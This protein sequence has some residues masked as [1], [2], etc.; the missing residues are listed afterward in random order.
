MYPSPDL[1]AILIDCISSADT[2]EE[3]LF[4]TKVE[5][6]R[7]R[8]NKNE[9]K[10]EIFFTNLRLNIKTPTLTVRIHG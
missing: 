9:V 8:I 7:I 6:D 3:I 5:K 10:T 2:T 1:A 4:L